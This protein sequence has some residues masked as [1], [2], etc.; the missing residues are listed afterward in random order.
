M[1]QVSDLS[2][3]QSEMSEMVTFTLTKAAS[4]P[5][6]GAWPQK[7]SVMAPVLHTP[8]RDYPAVP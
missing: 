3:K 1:V 4:T 5:G 6:H 7:A 8:V 2:S